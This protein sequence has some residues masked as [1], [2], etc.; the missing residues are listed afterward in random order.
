MDMIK[1]WQLV[2]VVCVLALLTYV[3]IVVRAFLSGMRGEERGRR[4]RRRP[5]T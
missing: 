1:P 4:C 5:R 2:T 3:V